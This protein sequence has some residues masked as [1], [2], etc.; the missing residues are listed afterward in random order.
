MEVIEMTEKLALI[1][2]DL[3]REY[4]DDGRPLKVPQGEKVLG[5][6]KSILE[7]GRKNNSMIV[8]VRHISKDPNDSTFNAA[9][10]YT[11]FI[12]GALPI[13]GEPVITKTRPGA[14]YLTELNDLLRQNRITKVAVFGLMSFLCCD[15]TAREAHARGYEVLFIKDAT[16]AIDLG[17]IPSETVNQ[18]TCA[19]QSV[20]F[21]T[22]IS[23][24]ELLEIMK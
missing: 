10:E 21:S 18:V 3:Q 12:D 7:Q 24:D 1:C 5:N 20:M 9:S 22:V 6:V 15:T 16:D 17:E 8:H 23:T 13:E 11:S 2:I 14:F 4:F 19:V